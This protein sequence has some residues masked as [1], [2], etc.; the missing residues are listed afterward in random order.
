MVCGNVLMMGR[1]AHDGRD[2][3][4]TLIFRR[5]NVGLVPYRFSFETIYFGVCLAKRYGI[6]NFGSKLK[7]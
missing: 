5:Y 2:S 7:L 4:F 6:Y 1:Y 3:R